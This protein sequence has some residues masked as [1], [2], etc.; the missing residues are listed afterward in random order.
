MQ[1]QVLQRDLRIYKF[2]R[3]NELLQKIFGSGE[4]EQETQGLEPAEEASEVEVDVQE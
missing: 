1:E 3:E 4:K 2:N